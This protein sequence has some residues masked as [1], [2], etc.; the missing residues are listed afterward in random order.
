MNAEPKMDPDTL[1]RHS[2]DGGGADHDK[3]EEPSIRM[4]P[5]IEARLPAVEETRQRVID[6]MEAMVREGLAALVR[7][8]PFRQYAPTPL[9]C[10]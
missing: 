9:T 6:E 1:L 10:L 2:D 7:W 3:L 8:V 5:P 4:L